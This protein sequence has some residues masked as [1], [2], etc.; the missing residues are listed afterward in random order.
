MIKFK[1]LGIVKMITF[2]ELRKHCEAN[3]LWLAINGNV[4]DVTAFLDDHPG[5]LK[6][7]LHFA[8]KDAT[9]GFMSKH[10]NVDITKFDKV[11]LVGTFLTSS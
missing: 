8:G 5:T 3:D 2:E 4:Y 7:L 1:S 6:P 9:S 11:K 10:P